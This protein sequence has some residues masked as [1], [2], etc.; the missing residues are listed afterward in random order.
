MGGVMAIVGG[1]GAGSAGYPIEILGGQGGA[2][3]TECAVQVELLAA[4]AEA[5]G[6]PYCGA[7]SSPTTVQPGVAPTW[8]LKSAEGEYNRG[9]GPIVNI[10]GPL[11]VGALVVGAAS[12]AE[13]H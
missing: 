3:D 2:A 1:M 11:A 12:L 6:N 8:A 10:S 13:L 5:G 4:T 7:L 9:G